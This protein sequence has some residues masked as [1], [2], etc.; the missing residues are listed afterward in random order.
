[1]GVVCGC[2]LWAWFVG[3]VCGCGLWAW[4]VGVVCGRGLWAWCVG[5]FYGRVLRRSLC[6]FIVGVVG[7]IPMGVCCISWN[8]VYSILKNRVY[9][10]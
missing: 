4:C 3:V 8:K 5:V 2:G 10:I 9:A 6:T 7:I 1:M